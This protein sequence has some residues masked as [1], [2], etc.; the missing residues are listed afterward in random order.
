[1]GVGSGWHRCSASLDSRAVRLLAVAVQLLAAPARPAVTTP[2]R[3]ENMN[4]TSEEL[5]ESSIR[6]QSGL[7]KT[8]EHGGRGERKQ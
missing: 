4:E 5:K 2:A 8:E 3:R 6:S 7:L 1:M